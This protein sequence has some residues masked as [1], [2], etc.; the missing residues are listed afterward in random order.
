MHQTIAFDQGLARYRPLEKVVVYDDFDRGF[1]GW[2]DLTPNFVNPGYTQ[3]RSRLDLGSWG[4]A[5]L[6]AAAMRFAASHG[7]MDGT[8][9]LK[10]STR[11]VAGPYEQPPVNGSLSTVIK[12]LS[13]SDSDARYIQLEAWYS[14]TPH[15]DREGLGEESIRA[16]GMWWDIQDGDYRWQPGIRYVNAVNGQLLKRWQYFAASD[17][18]TPTQWTGL[19]SEGWEHVGI[20]GMWCGNRYPDGSADA[21]QWVPNGGQSLVYNESPDKLNWMYLRLLVD[22]AAR[23][24]VEFQSVDRVFDLRGCKPTLARKY[25]GITQ[26]INPVFFIEAG[27]DRIVNL[28]LDSVVYSTGASLPERPMDG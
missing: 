20:D 15:Q 21:F 3:N 19:E 11:A 27:D 13:L 7:S 28:Y 9:S 2:L 6:S 25:A 14:Y 23:E 24:Y 12:R 1:N 4:P 16:F 5:Q 26:L 18:V 17:G 8:Y 10:L 22:L